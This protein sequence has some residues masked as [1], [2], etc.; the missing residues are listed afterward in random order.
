MPN[1][2]NSKKVPRKP[3]KL[4]NELYLDSR[5]KGER[6]GIEWRPLDC[7]KSVRKQ[8]ES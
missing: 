4:L 3:K 1:G 5:T 7:Y 6:D 2:V 8:T